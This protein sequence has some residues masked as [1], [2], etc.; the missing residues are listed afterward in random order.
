MGYILELNGKNENLEIVLE[1]IE[2]FSKSRAHCAL[3]GQVFSTQMSTYPENRGTA[4]RG[5]RLAIIL[6]PNNFGFVTSPF[7]DSVSPSVERLASEVAKI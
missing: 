1:Y 5:M 4:E 6:W 7:W 2:P 3:S